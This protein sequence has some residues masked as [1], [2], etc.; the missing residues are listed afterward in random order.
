MAIPDGRASSYKGGNFPCKNS[1]VVDF[2]TQVW[3]NFTAIICFL[4]K[5]ITTMCNRFTLIHTEPLNKV[6]N[7]PLFSSVRF[8]WTNRE[9][10]QTW[11]WLQQE[12]WTK[13]WSLGLPPPHR[14]GAKPVSSSGGL[15]LFEWKPAAG[16]RRH[17]SPGSWAQRN[18]LCP[19]A[20]QWS[21]SSSGR[22]GLPH[23]AGCTGSESTRG[24]LYNTD[25]VLTEDIMFT[26]LNW[27]YSQCL[28]IIT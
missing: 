28:F 22:L 14:A 12:R 8:Q 24:F 26:T 27:T 4:Y 3:T 11:L 6:N 19:A 7:H 5:Y 10:K 13:W 9:T 17:C 16:D 25:A 18:N 15:G 21:A 2:N 23:S 1:A 20:A